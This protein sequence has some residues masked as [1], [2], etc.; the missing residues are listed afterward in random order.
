MSCYAMK[1]KTF[2]DKATQGREKDFHQAVA[3]WA[4]TGDGTSMMV[5]LR[6]MSTDDRAQVTQLLTEVT[7]KAKMQASVAQAARKI[8]VS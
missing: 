8:E 3:V 6:E 7:R 4:K 1:W 2:L 5:M